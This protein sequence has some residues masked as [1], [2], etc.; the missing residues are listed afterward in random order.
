MLKTPSLDKVSFLCKLLIYCANSDSRKTSRT[1]SFVAVIENPNKLRFC[2]RKT[3][4]TNKLSV[5]KHR[6]YSFCWPGSRIA[7]AISLFI[8]FTEKE[9]GAPPAAIENGR[10]SRSLHLYSTTYNSEVEY[11]CT[12]NSYSMIG[13]PIVRCTEDGVWSEL[14]ICHSK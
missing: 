3:L 11:M 6:K 9:C 5:C 13:S 10:L 4:S 14:P 2:L 12:N 7:T 1:L 8:F